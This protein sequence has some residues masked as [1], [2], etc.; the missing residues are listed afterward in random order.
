M[1]R[2]I[3]KGHLSFGLVNIPVVL[4]PAERRTELHLHMLDSRNNARVRYARVNAATGEKVPWDR[5]VKG[6]E[7]DDDNYIVLKDEDIKRVAPEAT[8]TVE[9]EN[10]VAEDS[11]DHA[12]FDTPYCLTPDKKGEKG[13][14]LLRETL[15]RTKRIGIAR[16]VLRTK[17]HLAALLTWQEALLLNLLRFHDELIDLGEYN[18]PRQDA[19]HYKVSPAEVKM[20]ETLVDSMTVAWQP[21]R[22]HD[23]YSEKLLHYIEKRV[24]QGDKAQPPTAEETDTR[25]ERGVIN[26]MDLLK[27]SVQEK[28]REPQA[29]RRKHA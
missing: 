13:Y 28:K 18:L 16:V 25:R 24:K 10:F 14:V 5:I 12:Y 11:I 22:Y 8:R 6:Y 19:K 2:P 17:Q 7:F 20:A 9:I 1:S 4:H 29:R 15:K 26:I 27:K 23:E 3:W 21:R